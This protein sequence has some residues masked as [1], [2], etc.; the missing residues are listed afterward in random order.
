M[1][2]SPASYVR[3]FEN[4]DYL[5]LIKE[6]DTLLRYIRRFEKKERA[7]DRSGDEWNICPDPEVVYQMY[8]EYLSELCA[9]MQRRYNEEYVFGK[10]TL[11]NN[12]K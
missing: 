7:G 12:K 11:S 2:I 5:T 4:A 1:M 10:K 9:L 8:L 3:E 6:R